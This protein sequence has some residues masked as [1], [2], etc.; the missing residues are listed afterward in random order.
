MITARTLVMGAA[1]GALGAAAHANSV[2]R[3]NNALLDAVA[4]SSTP[5][6]VASR[7]MAM[8]QAA[9][10][11]AVN[12]MDGRWTSYLPNAVTVTD[13]CSRKAAVATAAHAV[14]S[15][16]YPALQG[17]FDALLNRQLSGLNNTVARDNGAALGLACAQNML[18]ARA[19]DGSGNVVPY[20]PG[21][22]PGQW[23][24]TLPNFAPG[25][26]PQWPTMTPFT[27]TAGDQFRQGGPPALD[28]AQYAASLNQV[29]EL[30]RIDSA[31]RT[32]DQT[33]IAHLWAAGGGTVTPPGQWNQIAQQIAHNEGMSITQSTRLFAALGVAVADA[34][35]V[36]W[37]MKYEYDFWRPITAIQ[38]ADTDGNDATEADLSWLPLL[39]TPPFPEY[40]SGHSTFSR[41]A[42]TI[43]QLV[44]GTDSHS[45]TVTDEALGITRSFTSLDDAANEAGLSRI[46]GGIH[47]DFSNIEGQLAG[48]MLGEYIYANYFLEVPAPGAASLGLLG[49]LAAARRR[50]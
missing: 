3:W 21:N 17:D 40:V 32:A 10:Y 41:A 4:T 20:T 19:N 43:L 12:A 1:L 28:S 7:A 39:P 36:A 22:L 35:I 50:R 45:F 6:P 26:L 8:T 27:M 29:K 18:A 25:L 11:D 15:S 47:Y 9:V 34:A 2:T 33:E 23:R 16:L 38:L 49:L 14:L 31:T 46:Y 5:P 30:G 48:Q 42:A 13:P 37:D 44:T 24:P